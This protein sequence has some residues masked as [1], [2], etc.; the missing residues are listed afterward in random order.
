MFV[1]MS[2]YMLASLRVTNSSSVDAFTRHVGKYV[3]SAQG[4]TRRQNILSCSP[5][6]QSKMPVDSNL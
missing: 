1:F 5:I 6:K 2:L 4:S 3:C